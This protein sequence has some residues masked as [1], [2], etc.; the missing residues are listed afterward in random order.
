[1][2]RRNPFVTG[3]ASKGV[4]D[5][6][7]LDTPKKTG[8]PGGTR[9]P[10]PQVRRIQEAQEVTRVASRGLQGAAGSGNERRRRRPDGPIRPRGSGPRVG[11]SGEHAHGARS[12]A[13]SRHRRAPARA[14]VS[15]QAD[16]LRHAAVVAQD[17][18]VRHR[19]AEPKRIGLDLSSLLHQSVTTRTPLRRRRPMR[20]ACGR[21]R[22]T[23][24]WETSTDTRALGASSPEGA[25][26]WPHPLRV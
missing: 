21:D 11:A 7:H 2:T 18:G 6:L 5:R 22:T 17:L 20:R 15:L 24:W 9:T 19:Q 4:P 10:D 8:A 12:L 23:T 26:W 13:P 1:M 14:A 25:T 3:C 16:Q